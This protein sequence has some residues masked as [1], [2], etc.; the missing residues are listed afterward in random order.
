MPKKCMHES[1]VAFVACVKK[2]STAE[3]CISNLEK[4]IKFKCRKDPQ[5]YLRSELNQILEMVLKQC[6]M[7][8]LDRTAGAY[9]QRKSECFQEKEAF[10]SKNFP[11]TS[12]WN[13]NPR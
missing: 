7:R 1:N 11:P 5:K 10:K 2:S 8:P 3:T 4:D 6:M 9:D 13:N 12:L